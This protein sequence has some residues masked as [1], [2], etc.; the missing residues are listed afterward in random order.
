MLGW[1]AIA[2]PHR[3]IKCLFVVHLFEYSTHILQYIIT[4][5]IVHLNILLA[6]SVE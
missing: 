3:Q 5:R 2:Q 4:A 6:E 1:E